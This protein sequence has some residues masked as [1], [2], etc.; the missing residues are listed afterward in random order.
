MIDVKTRDV[1]SKPVAMQHQALTVQVARRHAVLSFGLSCAL[2]Y[3]LSSYTL[4]IET[5][6]SNDHSH[7]VV[8]SI[9]R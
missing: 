2:I 4:S 1:I 8:A 6:S 3:L 9:D 7:G 5:A